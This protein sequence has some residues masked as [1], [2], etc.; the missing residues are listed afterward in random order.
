VRSRGKRIISPAQLFIGILI[1]VSFV[2]FYYN[3]LWSTDG[4]QARQSVIAFYTL[5][6]SGNYGSAWELFHTSMHGK[7]TKEAYIQKK[8]QVF[9]QQLGASTFEFEVGKS[10]GVDTWGMSATSPALTDV[11]RVQVTQHMLTVFGELELNQDIYVAEENDEW[12]LL[13]SYHEH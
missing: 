9:M 6:Q 8:A 4:Y 1:I 2:L 7:Y 10:K 13:L 12:K 3:V 11:Q 5:E